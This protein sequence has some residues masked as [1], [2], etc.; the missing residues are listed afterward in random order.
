MKTIEVETSPAT[1]TADQLAYLSTLTTRRLYQL[2]EEKKIPPADNGRFPMV[3]TIRQLFL[4][5]QRDG[6][7]LSREKLRLATA[8][9]KLA[10]MKAEE[11]EAAQRKRWIL[12]TD[13]MRMISAIVQKMEQAPGKI[14]SEAGLSDSQTAVVQRVLDAARSEAADEVSAMGDAA[15]Q[16]AK[17]EKG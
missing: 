5:F 12:A 14:R 6:E 7:A 2:A 13:H 8:T 11:S 4:W 15:K 10:E 17:D 16:E 1:I 3:E 9:R